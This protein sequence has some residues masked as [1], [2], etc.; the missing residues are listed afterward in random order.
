[1]QENITETPAQQPSRLEV[2]ASLLKEEKPYR[3]AQIAHAI[4]KTKALRYSEITTLS[5]SLR[6]AIIASL[7]DEILTLRLS[8][9]QKVTQASKALFELFDKNRIEAVRMEFQNDHTSLCISS[10]VGCQCACAFCTTGR[11]SF[12]RSLSSD[13]IADQPL[14]FMKNNQEV[15]NVA[16]MG[17]GEPFLNPNLFDALR[18]LTDPQLMGLSER[19]LTLSTVGIPEGMIRLTNA[20]PQISLTL[21]LHSPFDEERNSLVPLNN[22]YPIEELFQALEEHILKTNKKT[23]I[24]YMVLSGKNDTLDHAKKLC[25]LLERKNLRHL[26]LVNL[27]RYNPPLHE[28][29]IFHKTEKSSLFS[30]KELLETKGVHVTIRQ[31]FGSE[32]GAACGQLAAEYEQRT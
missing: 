28:N 8:K 2:L 24:A 16:F 27:I 10:Q 18:L 19:R 31:S 7:G 22:K 1:M 13:E 9:T 20:F 6:D 15:R 21:S 25:S 32:I 12:R 3:R 14:F 17:M 23:Y 29:T 26:F 5:K 4:F 11:I 30:F